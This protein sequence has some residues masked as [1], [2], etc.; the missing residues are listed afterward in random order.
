MAPPP[1]TSARDMR[2]VGG[3]AHGPLPLAHAAPQRARADDDALGRTQLL[4]RALELL[5][6]G[7]VGAG[8]QRQQRAEALAPGVAQRARREAAQP[9]L[10]PLGDRRPRARVTVALRRL[11]MDEQ[12]A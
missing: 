4:Q 3:L 9:P 6:V 1:R 8:A 7:V 10:G 12:M 5:P 11:D 2:R